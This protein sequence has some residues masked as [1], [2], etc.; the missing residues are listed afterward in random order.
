M[1]APPPSWQTPEITH[2]ANGVRTDR[3]RDHPTHLQAAHSTDPKRV[4]SIQSQ[5]RCPAF[6]P[7]I[8]PPVRAA[9]FDSQPPQAL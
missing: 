5:P 6:Q 3:M 7:E 1:P 8:R 9:F 2:L 4:N